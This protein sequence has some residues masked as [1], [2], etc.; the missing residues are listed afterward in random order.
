MR[1]K[2]IMLTVAMALFAAYNA[3]AQ[4]KATPNKQAKPAAVN[5]DSVEVRKLTDAAKKGNSEAQ[6]TLGTYYY[7]GKKVKRTMMWL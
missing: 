1:Y 6:N 3:T 4:K 2:Y 7:S 5:A